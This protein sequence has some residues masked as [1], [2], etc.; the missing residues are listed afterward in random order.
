VEAT[1][2]FAHPFL[3]FL[4]LQVPSEGK[5]EEEKYTATYTTSREKYKE[6]QVM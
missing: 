4:K 5:W 6:G 1:F 2:A 3:R